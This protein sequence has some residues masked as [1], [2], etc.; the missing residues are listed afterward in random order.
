MAALLNNKK[1]DGF[2]EGFSKTVV[3][4]L[5][6]IATL[7]ALTGSQERFIKYTAMVVSIV[8]TLVVAIPPIR[9]FIRLAKLKIFPKRMSVEQRRKLTMLLRD[10]SFYVSCNHTYSVFYTWGSLAQ[11]LKIS[12]WNRESYFDVVRHQL[13]DMCEFTEKFSRHEAYM[14]EKLSMVIRSVASSAEFIRRDVE[15]ELS[16]SSAEEDVKRQVRVGWNECIDA[17]NIWLKEWER[18]FKEA[19]HFVGTSCVEYIQVIKRMD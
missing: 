2:L 10:S 11:T 1:P 18:L 5:G 6:V 17:F 12:N 7:V 14:L 8:L 4:V 15:I 19:N 3:P 9:S 13:N 16:R